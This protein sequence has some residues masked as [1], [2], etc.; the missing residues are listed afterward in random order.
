[1]KRLALALATLAVLPAYL[2]Y[3]LGALALGPGKAFQGWSHAFALIP[4]LSGVYLRRAFYRLTLAGCGEDACLS[5][6]SVFAGP[7]ARVGR[8]V[9]V[10]VY[11]CLGESVLEDD[12]LLASGVSVV[13]GGRQHGTDRL[14][15][16]I[17]RQPGVWESVTVGRGAWVG[18]R[19]VVMADVGA[20][21]I[22]GAGAVVTEAVPDYAIAVG[23][24][25]K[26]IAYRGGARG[27]STPAAAGPPLT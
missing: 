5:F 20:H 6:G 27:P 17:R 9:F 25:A 19:A 26:V 21:C 14:D 18:E 22:I 3:R 7:D 24:P 11:C 12:V 8:G 10:G 15:V 13:N 16:P 1:M 2:L 4:G 23:V